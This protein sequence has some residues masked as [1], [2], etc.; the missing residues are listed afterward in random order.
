MY[1]IKTI[2]L[3]VCLAFIQVSLSA[4]NNTNSPYSR[5]AYGVLSDQA[6]GGQRA[7]GGI[8]FGLRDPKM[9]NPLNPASFS[10][11]DS[12]T[13]MLDLGI[14][15]QLAWFNDQG[16]KDKK[17]NGNIEYIAMQFPLYKDLGM[18]VGFKPIS[19]VGYNYGFTTPKDNNYVTYTSYTGTGGLNQVYGAL[20]YNFFKRF[21]VGVNAGYIFGNI[22]HDRQVTSNDATDMVTSLSDTLQSSGF[23]YD[24]GIQY[25]HPLN[26][27]SRIVLGATYTPKTKFNGKVMK[28]GITYNSSSGVISYSDRE[29]NYD[30]GFQLP[31]SFGI[32]ATY[33]KLNKLTVGADFLLQQWA[34][35]EYESKKDTLNNRTKFNAGL[36]YIPDSRSKNFFKRMKYRAGGYYSDSYVKVQGYGYKEY[37]ASVGIG[38][39]MIDDR[40][41]LNITFEYVT[42]R[43]ELKTLIDEQYFKFT[44][45][46]TFNELWFFKRKIQ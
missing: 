19:Y 4:Q 44:V 36:E 32:G 6:F 35:A 16:N 15:G 5:Y 1:K 18:G 38:I 31:Q 8:G 26:K 28:T 10:S 22:K 11:V 43:P 9:I 41:R 13:F 12:M 34:D 30:Y 40:S 37:G 23:T 42:I 29:V 39:P 7:M 25:T 21:S 2:L 45:S 14:T 24:L 46:Y 20:S 33:T 27:D 3:L 17:F